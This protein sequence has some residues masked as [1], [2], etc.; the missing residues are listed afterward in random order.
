MK[1]FGAALAVAL[2]GII[3]SIWGITWPGVLA[4]GL[5]GVVLSQAM[6]STGWR[7]VLT[8]AG[9][10][11]LAAAGIGAFLILLQMFVS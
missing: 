5:V 3:Y 9:T 1:I 10:I 8:I 11:C 6:H 7:E 4:A 2:V